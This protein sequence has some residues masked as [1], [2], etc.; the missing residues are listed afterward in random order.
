MRR[1]RIVTKEVVPM[2][3]V[4]TVSFC[5]RLRDLCLML[6]DV[7]DFVGGGDCDEKTLKVLETKLEKVEDAVSVLHD[8]VEDSDFTTDFEKLYGNHDPSDGPFLSQEPEEP[9]GFCDC[10]EC[11]GD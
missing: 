11:C 4:E 6:D 7:E 3:Y 1:T 2:D 5:Q 9:D 10:P 8:F